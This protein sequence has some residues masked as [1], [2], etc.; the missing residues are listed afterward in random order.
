MYVGNFDSPTVVEYS[1]DDIN[2]FVSDRLLE[3]SGAIEPNDDNEG[4]GWTKPLA[5]VTIT[6][7]SGDS[8]RDN[9]GGQWY[10][11]NEVVQGKWGSYGIFAT[12]GLIGSSIRIM[13]ILA[14]LIPDEK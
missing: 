12:A 8:W 11:Q 13:L 2:L 6:A 5:T 4:T 1:A 14:Q 3:Y 10:G 7:S 9:F